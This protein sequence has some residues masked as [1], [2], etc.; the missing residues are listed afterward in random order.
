MPNHIAF[1]KEA[2]MCPKEESSIDD[3][4]RMNGLYEL[5]DL[6]LQWKGTYSR[7]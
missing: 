5:H 4:E 7:W 1:E 3:G 2:V 6:N